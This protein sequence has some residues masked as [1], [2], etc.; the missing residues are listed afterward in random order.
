MIKILIV[1]D[2]EYKL[3]NIKSIIFDNTNI[4]SSFVQ[5]AC[6][7]KEAKRLLYDEDYDLMLLDL[8]IPNEKD[9]DALPEVGIMLLDDIYSNPMI[10]PPIQI[11]GLTGFGE[12]IG[13]YH[14]KFKQKLWHLINYEA[15]STNWQEQLK[16]VIFH[17]VKT[18]EKFIHT[19]FRQNLYDI[20]IITALSKP[21]LEAILKLGTKRWDTF[22]IENEI[23]HF[24][25][26]E[27]DRE[28]KKRTIV[29]ACTDQMG[30]VSS[31]YL[32][33]KILMYFQPK[34]VIMAGIAAGIK[35]RNLGFGDILIAEQSWD[36][37][38]GKMADNPNNTNTLVDDVVF[39]PDLRPIPLS[40][41][42]KAKIQSFIL[43]DTKIL[44]EIQNNWP[45]ESPTTKLSAHLGPIASGS[46]VIATDTTLNSIK[47]QQRKLL[48]I[49]MEGYGVYY[50]AERSS[51]PVS[52][53][54]LIKSVTDYGD[55]EKND[56]FQ[57]YA[58]YT[59]ANFIYEFILKYL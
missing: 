42:L 40:S 56:K 27:F 45:G 59:S 36:Y 31:T 55:G 5:V 44:D 53:A 30:M 17:L 39:L 23:I 51:D 8:V 11:V 28:G 37:G 54:I 12:L 25:K 24:Y 16:S 49:E 58:A 14:Q 43:N 26:T 19:R 2:N 50:A 4:K 46:Y 22:Q 6:S 57:K 33:T 38:S 10:H 21:E 18:R 9:D 3:Q 32:A 47:D 13:E 7:S 41:E 52:H 20:A 35:D 48:G 29:A 1:E 15:D 34:Y